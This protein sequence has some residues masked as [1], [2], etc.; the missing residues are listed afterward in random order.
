MERR[1]AIKQISLGLG[2]AVAM[3]TLLNILSSCTSNK[4]KVEYLFLNEEQAVLIVKLVNIIMPINDFPNREQI[5][6]IQFIDEMFYYTEPD[7]EKKIFS[8]GSSHFIKRNPDFKTI[9][10]NYFNMSRAGEAEVFKLLDQE[11]QSIEGRLKEKYT[12]Y[13]FLTKVRDYCLLGYCTSKAYL[14]G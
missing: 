14:N 3:P 2:C 4:R 6:L 11:Y 1:R 8:L 9:I 13:F 5:N 7:K 12:T 10:D